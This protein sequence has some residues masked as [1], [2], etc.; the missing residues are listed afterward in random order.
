MVGAPGGGVTVIAKT[1]DATPVLPAASVAV[2]VRLWA[3]FEKR[4][5]CI[6]P[7]AAIGH[8]AVEQ[9]RTVKDLDR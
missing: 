6:S 4:R 8:H 2:A 3:P 9:R 7:G 1:D 5:R